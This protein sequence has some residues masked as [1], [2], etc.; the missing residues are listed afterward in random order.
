[1]HHAKKR[2][3]IGDVLATATS[4]TLRGTKRK[5]VRE[6]LDAASFGSAYSKRERQRAERL[7]SHNKKAS[8]ALPSHPI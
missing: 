7:Q 2:R 5:W 6:P 1:L 3:R 4:K 8:Q